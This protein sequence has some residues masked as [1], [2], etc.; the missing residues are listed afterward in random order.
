M[1]SSSG[2]WHADRFS[3][4]FEAT[5]TAVESLSLDGSMVPVG[6]DSRKRMHVHFW[7][8]KGLMHMDYFFHVVT[9]FQSKSGCCDSKFLQA[10]NGETICPF[11]LNFSGCRKARQSVL[12]QPTQLSFDIRSP[13]FEICDICETFVSI[14]LVPLFCVFCLLILIRHHWMAA[15]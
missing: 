2:A 5:A 12:K 10:D 14:L 6:H 13:Y 8:K 4:K 3:Y 15:Q 1:S 9:L 7:V 11:V